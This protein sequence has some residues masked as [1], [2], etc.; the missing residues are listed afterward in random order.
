M[1][2][3]SK[4]NEELLRTIYHKD[5][6]D[7]K[8]L[9]PIPNY[10]E[11][12]EEYL[13]YYTK[14][15]LML[16]MP[17]KT[18]Y[19]Y[20]YDNNIGNEQLIAIYYFGTRITF[21]EFFNKIN[22]C[23]NALLNNGI[24]IG[25]IVTVIM[26]NTPEALYMI[27][28][29]NKIGAVA[30]MLH[31][32]SSQN[33]MRDY[34][35]E[36]E[37]DIVLVIDSSYEKLKNVENQ[38]CAKKIIVTSP[39]DS[40]DIK[41]KIGYK[42]LNIKKGEKKVHLGKK[43]ISWK[44]FMADGNDTNVATVCND[45]NDF[46]ILLRTGGTTGVSK[47]VKLSN[48]NF[49][50]MVEQLMTAIKSYNAGD[51]FLSIMPVFHGFGLCSSIH[52]PL[53]HGVGTILIPKPDIKSMDKLFNELH[54]NHMVGVPTLFK[55]FMKVVNNNIS[56]GKLKDF[57]LSYVKNIVSGGDA[58]EEGYVDSV[59]NF[60]K[61]HGSNATLVNGY[62]LTE[63]VAGVTF[64]YDSCSEG[65]G[66]PMTHSKLKI[67]NQRTGMHL[68]NGQIGEICVKS[69]CVMQG[70][71]KHEDETKNTIIDG[72]LHTG[73]IGYITNG[74]LYFVQRKSNMIISSGVNVYPSEI[75][76]II[77]MHPSVQTSAVIGINH[78]YKQEVPKAFVVLKPGCIMNEGIK[79]EIDQ[80][81]RR[82]L[83]KYSI[84]YEYEF[85]DRLPETLLGK[86]NLKALTD[87]EKTRSTI[88]PKAAI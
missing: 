86:I 25:D 9:G 67:V 40:M 57:D 32:L 33:E 43:A 4:L 75:E 27:Y 41:T 51:K 19:Q 55:G 62:G 22:H 87:E 20:V 64:S 53:S 70:Y 69:P 11:E 52:L 77:N 21:K 76:K 73:D 59:N 88:K 38:C 23:A 85:R 29:L 35:N 61:K 68:E 84:P 13:K 15:E 12:A 24:K 42:L 44:S 47:A 71:Y 78:P 7:G 37:S 8:I 49:N 14:S 28:A 3:D 54:P 26:P 72:W 39:E 6:L 79:E 10:P 83:N 45:K 65:C 63:A 82:N 48:D 60:F 1:I 16:N 66:I 17:S 46:S 5:L 50:S 2:N 80:L 74:I 36:E 31:P 30:S 81:C 56:N 34:I 18:M 58:S